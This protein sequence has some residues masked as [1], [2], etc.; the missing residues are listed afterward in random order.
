MPTE[1]HFSSTSTKPGLRRKRTMSRMPND[2]LAR[3]VDLVVVKRGALGG[4]LAYGER[5]EYFG[6]VP[7]VLVSP[8][9]SG[10][11]FSA[12]FAHA[13]QLERADPIEAVRF[14]SKVAAC[15]STSGLAQVGEAVFSELPN[16]LPYPTVDAPKVYLA[17]PF[18]SV[19]ER[20]MIRFV[21]RALHHLG[22][23]VF[24]PL[25]DVGRGGDEV[26]SQDI[27]GL[28]QCNSVLA[29]LDGG[30]P[31]TLF[32]VGW[33]CSAGIPVVGL[34]DS[35]GDHSW[36]MIRG[37]GAEVT[38]DLSAAVYHATWAGITRGASND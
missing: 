23:E 34:A 29:L 27:Q 12:G 20:A 22:A 35:A 30:D 2:F 10:D 24:S 19:A 15:H 14:A 18:F 36:T 32:E 16:P 28:M 3:G 31:G 38:S 37:L 6:A 9:G 7:T 25:D 8:M 26:A 1:S 5:L 33:A 11:A 21:R 4:I 13:W 17:G